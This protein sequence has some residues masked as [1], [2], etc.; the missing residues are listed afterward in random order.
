MNP[1]PLP[2]VLDGEVDDLA[3]LDGLDF[4]PSAKV[5]PVRCRSVEVSLAV[6]Y[7]G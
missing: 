4:T 1:E 2:A 3:V 7:E 5:R 6:L